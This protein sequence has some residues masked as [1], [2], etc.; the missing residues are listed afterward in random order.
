M[1]EGW[2]LENRITKDPIFF[3]FYQGCRWFIRC[4]FRNCLGQKAKALV[5]RTRKFWAFNLN[6][7]ALKVPIS[8]SEVSYLC[9]S[10]LSRN[11]FRVI[12]HWLR[13]N[14]QRW[15]Q[16][17]PYTFFWTPGSCD[18]NPLFWNQQK[19]SSQ[20]FRRQRWQKHCDLYIFQFLRP[21]NILF[22]AFRQTE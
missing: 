21:Y 3:N 8:T 2:L 4:A 13:L 5:C 19:D 10:Q 18:K 20:D 14:S 1:T 9:S 16:P 11:I 7:S 12:R 22:T 17:N 6:M 15:S